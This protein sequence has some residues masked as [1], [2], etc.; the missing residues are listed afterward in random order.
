MLIFIR[1][2]ITSHFQNQN[3]KKFVGEK[4]LNRARKETTDGIGHSATRLENKI[5]GSSGHTWF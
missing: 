2:V 5:M 4:M 3:G 1:H